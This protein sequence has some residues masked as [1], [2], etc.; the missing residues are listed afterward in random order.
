MFVYLLIRLLVSILKIKI[1]NKKYIIWKNKVKEEIKEN[2]FIHNPNLESKSTRGE[3]K[4]S[5][6]N[7]RVVV[8]LSS[9]K[10]SKWNPGFKFTFCSQAKSTTT[11]D[12]KHRF[13][14]DGRGD[15]GRQAKSTCCTLALPRGRFL[16]IV[17]KWSALPSGMQEGRGHFDAWLCPHHS[18]ASPLHCDPPATPRHSSSRLVS[19]MVKLFLVDEHVA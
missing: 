11:Y 19:C 2:Y 18:W 4:A 1:K 9:H 7:H 14:Q 15:A 8:R 3:S 6:P 12:T 16:S 17:D 10:D 13:L 5:F